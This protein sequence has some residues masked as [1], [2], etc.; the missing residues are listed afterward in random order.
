MKP[1]DLT[2]LIPTIPARKELYDALESELYRQI[3]E[4]R[5]IYPEILVTIDN[6]PSEFERIGTKRNNLLE[7]AI[8]KYVAFFD[9]DDWPGENYILRNVEGVIKGVDACSLRGIITW[10]G[11]NPEVFEH[12]LNYKKYET[13]DGSVYPDFKY[14]RFNNHINCMK[15]SIAKQFKFPEINHGEDTDFATQV[16]NSGL[17]QTEHYIDEVI[18]HYRFKPNK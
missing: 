18:Y 17:I 4:V 16:F 14:L 2:I 10:D 7:R 12:S 1:F 3:M 9:D 15:S 8:S 13:I 11:V 5:K 6:D